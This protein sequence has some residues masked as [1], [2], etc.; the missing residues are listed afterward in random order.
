MGFSCE[1]FVEV[2]IKVRIGFWEIAFTYS[3]QENTYRY[4]VIFS[5]DS[6]VTNSNREM[7]STSSNIKEA[8]FLGLTVKEHLSN[9]EL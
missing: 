5:T 7:L 9:Q 6:L 1:M 2:V 3:F 4:L 8:N